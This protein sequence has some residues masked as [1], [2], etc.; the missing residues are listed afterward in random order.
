MTDQR[1]QVA[2]RL[3]DPAFNGSFEPPPPPEAESAIELARAIV[4]KSRSRLKWLTI[5]TCLAWIVATAAGIALAYLYFDKF[6]N[7][8]PNHEYRLA[9]AHE[10]MREKLGPEH[11]SSYSPKAL[12]SDAEYREYEYG[13]KLIQDGNES[14]MLFS[15][16]TILLFGI[17]ALLSVWLISASRRCTMKQINANLAS[18]ALD[19]RAL[20]V[21]PTPDVPC[22]ES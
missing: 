15:Q 11:R 21:E 12:L 9:K 8:M 22:L 16:A 2:Q 13:Y 10:I 1:R 19:L 5:A 7:S 20:S 6:R 4:T 18:L 3:S 17:A 14:M